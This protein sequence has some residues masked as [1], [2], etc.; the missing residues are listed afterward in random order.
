MNSSNIFFSVIKDKTFLK[1]F[2]SI[3]IP[4]F[5]AQ[6]INN[7]LQLI[8]QFMLSSLG[9]ATITAVGCVNQIFFLFG[10]VYFGIAS[11]AGIFFARLWQQ[12][13]IERIQEIQ[14]ISLY[15]EF[16]FSIIV[17]FISTHLANP[18]MHLYTN[19][20]K[21]ISIGTLYFTHISFGQPFFALSC[22][23]IYLFR[24][25]GDAIIGT[26]GS[27]IAVVLNT[28]LNYCFIFGHLGAPRLGVVGAAFSTTIARFAMFSYF[29]FKVSSK[30]KYF[31]LKM[32]QIIRIQFPLLKQILFISISLVA[33]DLAIALSL[34][35]YIGIFSHFGTEVGAAYS[36]SL[37]LR[38]FALLTINSASPAC[39]I[40]MGYKI[41]NPHS[42]LRV[43]KNFAL[44]IQGLG[45]YL[46]IGIFIV[47]LLIEPLILKYGFHR[48]SF[49]IYNLSF[50][51]IIIMCFF[52]PIANSNILFG[53]AIFRAGGDTK[54]NVST[55]LLCQFLISISVA[56]IVR[57]Y[58]M[59]PLYTYY[60][61][62]LGDVAR[63][64]I[65]IF[66]FKY[67]KWIKVL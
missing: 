16:I 48:L 24:I 37:V 58:T 4:L 15:I 13:N 2:T 50:H 26:K 34:N 8:D 55:V 47:I 29:L 38:Q 59:N 19:D 25:S 7:G 32:K 12:K 54:I 56:L 20:P 51:M 60:S 49:D 22:V 31:I 36:I 9:T 18:I 41:G 64:V 11:S 62:F 43:I 35:I 17:I 44:K 42:T 23:Y 66:Y 5:I 30:A 39:M 52:L 14:V 3:A 57:H 33:G 28:F 40:L 21:V 63:I 27:I 45:L 65:N 1:D 53:G 67:A 10:V 61:L 46:S 6:I